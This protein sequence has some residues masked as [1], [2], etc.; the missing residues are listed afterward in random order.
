MDCIAICLLALS[1][2]MRPSDE[3]MRCRYCAD[4]RALTA[5]CEDDPLHCI[6]RDP[7][8][9][10]YCLTVQEFVVGERMKQSLRCVAYTDFPAGVNVT[11]TM[12]AS[13]QCNFKVMQTCECDTCTTPAKPTTTT[14]TSPPARQR[15]RTKPSVSRPVFVPLGKTADEKALKSTEYHRPVSEPQQAVADA[16]N[17]GNPLSR[18]FSSSAPRIHLNTLSLLVPLS[19]LLAI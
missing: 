3:N 7:Q 19:F 5:E 14:T 11:R 2:G 18:F 8:S 13:D 10:L 16:A 4:V 12:M 17:D 9:L 6:S 15:T 1:V